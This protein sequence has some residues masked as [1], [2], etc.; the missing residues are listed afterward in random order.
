MSAVTIRPQFTQGLGR[1]AR[2]IGLILLCR[3]RDAVVRWIALIIISRTGTRSDPLSHPVH[4]V[5]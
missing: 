3:A 1:L 2:M 4:P 5:P